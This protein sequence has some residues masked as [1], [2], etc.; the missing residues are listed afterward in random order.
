M[1]L[2]IVDDQQATL[3]GVAYGIDWTDVGFQVVETASNAMEARLCFSRG[4]PDVMLCDIEMPVESGIELCSW[5]RQQKYSTRILFL[6][7]HS[8][9]AF[10]QEAIKLQA[11][12]YILQP[13][14]YEEIREKVHKVVQS[15]KATKEETHLQKIGKGYSR[16][17]K[18]VDGS[19]W[20]GYLLGTL[21]LEAMQS[22]PNMPSGKT[23]GWLILQ[24]LVQWRE[25]DQGWRKGLLAEALR[26]FIQDVFGNCTE[27]AVAV[28]MEY[29]TYAVFLQPKPGAMDQRQLVSKLEYLSASYD[30]Y[31]PCSCGFYLTELS[32]VSQMPDLWEQ[33]LYCRDQSVTGRKG[34]ISV[35]DWNAQQVK[36]F[37]YVPQRQRWI[38]EFQQGGKEMLLGS[39]IGD[40]TALAKSESVSRRVLAAFLQDW[41]DTLSVIGE[42]WSEASYTAEAS[43][44]HRRSTSSVEDMLRLLDY[45]AENCFREEKKSVP[46]QI[47]TYIRDNIYNDIRKEDIAQLV[48]LNGDYVTRLFKKETGYSVK[49]FI[50]RE[51]MLVARQLLQTTSLSVGSIAMQLS[52]SNFSHFSAAYKKEFGILPGDEK[53][54]TP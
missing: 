52:Y 5:V 48:H 16:K 19:L 21:N 28:F 8:D 18:L 35:A 54:G 26:N 50:I 42:N 29:N 39:V 47:V 25:S 45:T 13:A 34:V 31:M 6:T 33:L 53:R 46:Q 51:K 27:R 38:Q 44:L 17:Q 41:I 43:V 37:R 49:S 11:S 40:L 20:R 10:A 3:N 32:Q 7:C 36:T 4:V 12:D 30:M 15:L 14:S 24:H 1:K 9:F 2:L 23:S 22:L